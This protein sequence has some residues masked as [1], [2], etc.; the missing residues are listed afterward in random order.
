MMTMMMMMMIRIK[1]GLCRIERL[2][3]SDQIKFD[4]RPAHMYNGHVHVLLASGQ[5]F[6]LSGKFDFPLYLLND[7]L[8]IAELS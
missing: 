2:H 5:L 7:R 3:I 6:L 4:R 8:D 1:T